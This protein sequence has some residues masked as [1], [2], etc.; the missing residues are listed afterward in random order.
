MKKTVG[1]LFCMFLSMFTLPANA[2]VYSESV[3][4]VH[5]IEWQDDAPV[6]LRLSNGTTCFVPALEKNMYSLLLSMFAT[7]KKA[8]IH[9]HDIEETYRGI[10]GYRV[11]RVISFAQ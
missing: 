9:C 10:S 6:Y 4:V 11:H 2:W 8:H 1:I 5:I 7:G 3:T